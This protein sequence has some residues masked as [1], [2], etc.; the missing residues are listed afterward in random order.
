MKALNHYIS[1]RAAAAAAAAVVVAVL[2]YVYFG[3]VQHSIICVRQ[4]QTLSLMLIILWFRK[5]I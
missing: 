2:L 4:G 3:T 1:K 5:H